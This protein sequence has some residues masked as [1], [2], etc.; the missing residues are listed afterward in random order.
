MQRVSKGTWNLGGCVQRYV[1]AG[2]KSSMHRAICT[3]PDY[4]SSRSSSI[5]HAVDAEVSV[6]ILF[7]RFRFNPPPVD[8]ASM[9]RGWMSANVLVDMWQRGRYFECVVDRR[10]RRMAGG[11]SFLWAILW[12]LHLVAHRKIDEFCLTWSIS[13]QRRRRCKHVNCWMRSRTKK[14]RKSHSNSYCFSKRWT[15]P[16]W[17]KKSPR[18]RDA[19]TLGAG[20]I[21]IE[22]LLHP[23]QRAGAH[24]LRPASS[25][26]WRWSFSIFLKARL[27]A[28]YVDPIDVIPTAGLVVLSRFLDK[29]PP[30]KSYQR[31]VAVS[32][33]SSHWL[34][35]PFQYSTHH[36]DIE[37]D[38]MDSACQRLRRYV[39]LDSLFAPKDWPSTTSLTW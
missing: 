29:P 30:P 10:K 11:F 3:R 23:P 20:V 33:P 2:L 36:I 38:V 12:Y 37:T 4:V 24:Q 25:N 17:R 31:Q 27:S 19:H 5:E 15:Q 16:S 34:G 21:E 18:I 35:F 14:K 13:I 39:T 26:R 28:I 1:L 7:H 22:L 32:P 9:A 8:Q 6:D